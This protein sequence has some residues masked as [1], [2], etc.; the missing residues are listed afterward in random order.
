[1]M[2]DHFYTMVCK[3]HGVVCGHEISAKDNVLASENITTM[4]MKSGYSALPRGSSALIDSVFI[5][6]FFPSKLK[7]VR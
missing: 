6:N 2:K 1:M 4:K 3:W 7:Y 5:I